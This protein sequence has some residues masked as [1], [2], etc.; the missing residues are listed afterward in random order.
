MIWEPKADRA[1]R[2]IRFTERIALPS[3]RPKPT[4]ISAASESLSMLALVASV[5]WQ[6]NASSTSRK[7]ELL[8]TSCTKWTFT[9]HLGVSYNSKLFH[10]LLIYNYS[11][12]FEFNSG[13]PDDGK[14]IGGPGKLSY[15]ALER[16]V[17]LV[18]AFYRKSIGEFLI[19]CCWYKSGSS[20][21]RCYLHLGVW[22]WWNQ[23]RQLRLRQLR[24]QRLH[25]IRF[26]FD[27]SR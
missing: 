14:H 9:A 12:E 18:N 25:A 8:I 10:S 22:E 4:T 19:Y 17:E 1:L 2:K 11:V 23:G 5:C 20:G 15:H 7:P 6:R 3:S 27:A 24:L 26:G 16:G 13:P 21:T